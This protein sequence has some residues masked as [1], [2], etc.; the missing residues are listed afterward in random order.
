MTQRSAGARKRGG[1]TA[2]AEGQR[3]RVHGQLAL[4]LLQEAERLHGQARPARAAGRRG[5]LPRGH[6]CAPCAARRLKPGAGACCAVRAPAPRDRPGG[7][8]GARR[9]RARPC[10]APAS[11]GGPA[12]TRARHTQGGCGRAAAHSLRAALISAARRRRKPAVTGSLH[13]RA[14]SHCPRRDRA[15]LH[16]RPYQG[17]PLPQPGLPCLQPSS[18][19][20][21]LGSHLRSAA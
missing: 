8:A 6:A 10:S 7:P 17:M 5:V 1:R 3:E 18:P 12:V 11:A 9:T 2:R 13:R 20:A 19:P 14:Q 16:P 4:V 15:G 21:C